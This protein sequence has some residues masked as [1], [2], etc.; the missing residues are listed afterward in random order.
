MQ[1]VPTNENTISGGESVGRAGVAGEEQSAAPTE[2]AIRARTAVPLRSIDAAA[3]LVPALLATVG[4]L[5]LLSLLRDVRGCPRNLNNVDFKIGGLLDRFRGQPR[6]FLGKLVIA[7]L[8]RLQRHG[9][10][11]SGAVAQTSGM[12]IPV[13]HRPNN[14]SI[15]RICC[16]TADTKPPRSGSAV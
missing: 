1:V 15:C 14:D 6:E 3:T 10:E 9:Q 12:V 7:I 2:T 16:V 8:A 11:P 13:G 5:R 4:R